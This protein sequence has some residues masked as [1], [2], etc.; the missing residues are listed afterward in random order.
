MPVHSV[1]ALVE[2]V[3]AA[4]P[5]RQAHKLRDEAINLALNMVLEGGELAALLAELEV[6]TGTKLERREVAR[7][8]RGIA[9]RYR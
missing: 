9:Y 1:A 4:V 8:S 3:L 5:D 7:V 6:R 2:D